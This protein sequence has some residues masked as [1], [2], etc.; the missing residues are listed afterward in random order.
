MA[1]APT[2]LDPSAF[3][4]AHVG[5]P[6]PAGTLIAFLVAVLAIIL[7]AGLSYGALESSLE[8]AQRVTHTLQIVEQL[9]EILSTLQDAETGQ[10]GFL[11]TSN[12]TYLAPYNNASAAIDGELANARKLLANNPA[13]LARLAILQ[14]VVSD[15]MSELAQTVAMKRAGDATGALAAVRTNRGRDAMER[16]RSTIAEMRQTEGTALATRQAE[17]L[18]A[19]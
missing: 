19:S 14:R 17:W 2:S 15:K 6:L 4:G 12:E 13:Q 5:P 11:L 1:Q 8:S 7:V 18:S 9:Q 3:R 10:R 16:A